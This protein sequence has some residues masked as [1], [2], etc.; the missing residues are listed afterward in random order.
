M[1][2]KTTVNGEWLT[3]P[4]KWCDISQLYKVDKRIVYGLLHKVNS[5]H[6][7]PCAQ[8]A[9]NVSLSVQVISRIV[10]AA[11]NTLVTEGKDKYTVGLNYT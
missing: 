9:M 8:S 11:I 4:A 7:Q 5:T 10:A 3:G 1:V 6:M 2:R